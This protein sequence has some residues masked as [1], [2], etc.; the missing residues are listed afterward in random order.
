RTPFFPRCFILFDKAFDDIVGNDPIKSYLTRM[1]EK[2]TLA[3]SL[4]FAGPEGTGKSLFAKNFAKLIVGTKNPHHPDIYHYHTE[5][6]IGMHSIQSMR[7]FREEVYL[8]PFEAQKKVF[9]IYDAHRMLTYSANALLKTFEEPA[10]NSIIILLSNCSERILPTIL[11]RCQTVRFLPIIDPGGKTERLKENDSPIRDLL[12]NALAEGALSGYSQLLHVVKEVCQHVQL[13]LKDEEELARSQLWKD[14]SDDLTATQKQ[15]I[16]KEVEG[17]VALQRVSETES[18]F[19]II[20]SWYRDMHLLHANADTQLLINIDYQTQL[21]QAL[22]RGEMFSLEKAQEAIS[23]AK[24]ALERSTP[25][26][27]CLENLFLNL[28]TPLA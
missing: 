4:L 6:K 7:Q 16:E 1:V 23:K 22:Q 28:G 3:Q 11:S 21:T 9:I 2:G 18:L 27:Y 25:L 12:L 13:K 14:F 17:Y 15:S 5:G 10:P 20:L 19:E 26:E 24:L 8:A